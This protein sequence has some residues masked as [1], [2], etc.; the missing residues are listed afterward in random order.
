[1][2]YC[3]EAGALLTLLPWTA[4]WS[5][6]LLRLPHS[7]GLALA[8]HPVLRG[9]VSGFGLVHLVWGAH[10]LEALLARRRRSR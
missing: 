5:Q 2:L 1:M 10:D 7:D 9:L 4:S 6:A 8:S 3:V